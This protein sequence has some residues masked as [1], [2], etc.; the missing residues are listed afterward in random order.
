MKRGLSFWDALAW[1]V[2]GLLIIW[3]ILK[4]FGVINTPV[5]IEYFPYFSLAYWAGWSIHKLMAVSGDVKQLKGFASD[6]I[7]EVNG[8]KTEINKMNLRCEFNH[9]KKK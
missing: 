4:V 2:L 7:K 1:I 6:T 9:S 5:L 8:V 3:L